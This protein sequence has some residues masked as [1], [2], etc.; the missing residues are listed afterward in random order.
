MGSKAARKALMIGAAAASLLTLGGCVGMPMAVTFASLYVDSVLV[1]RTGRGAAEHAVSAVAGRDCAFINLMEH[2]SYCLDQDP[3]Q[4]IAAVMRDLETEPLPAPAPE[5]VGAP[6]QLAALPSRTLTDAMPAASPQ[7]ERLQPERPQPERPRP[8]RTAMAPDA[9]VVVRAAARV[10]APRATS[11]VVVVGSFTERTQAERHRERLGRS[12]ADIVEA[13][14][15]GRLRH[16]VV[17]RPADRDGALRELADARSGGVPD[18]W[19]LAD[20]RG[21]EPQGTIGVMTAQLLAALL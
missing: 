15:F 17:L 21:H 5:P 2:G 18:A 16:R 1:T 4:L 12:D 13:V 10:Q 6:I 8:V 14:V 7:P 20:P 11:L 3:P 9:A 19:L